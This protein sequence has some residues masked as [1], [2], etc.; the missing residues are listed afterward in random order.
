MRELSETIRAAQR[1]I[2]LV[3]GAR[4]VNDFTWFEE[5]GLWGGCF[6]LVVDVV[7]NPFISRQTRWYA[8]LSDMYPLGELAVVPAKDGGITATFPHQLNNSEGRAELPW[9]TGKLCLDEDVVALGRLHR[10]RQPQSAIARFRWHVERAVEWIRLAAAGTLIGSSDYF[11]LPDYPRKLDDLVVY[12]ENALS[13]SA[14]AASSADAGLAFYVVVK[15]SPQVLAVHS[16]STFGGR[17]IW[18]TKWG[19]RFVAAKLVDQSPR[20]TAWI[21]VSN[22]LKLDPW[23]APLTWADLFRALDAQGLSR[24]RLLRR[25]IRILR[26]VDEPLRHL[27]VG[28]PVPKLTSANPEQMCW[29]A[30]RVDGLAPADKDVPGFRPTEAS[31]WLRDRT[32]AMAPHRELRWA[33]TENWS[34]ENLLGRGSL[35][36]QACRKSFLVIGAGAL[37]SVVAEMLVRGG[38]R[39]ISIVDSDR[40]AAGNLC[41][42]TLTVDEV[43]APK[44][45]AIASRLR[46]C[47]AHVRVREHNGSFASYFEGH[48]FKLKHDVIVDCTAENDVLRLLAAHP[49]VKDV[50]F[51]SASVGHHARHL[52]LFAFYGKAFPWQQFSVEMAPWSE[53]EFN[54]AAGMD[55]ARDGLGC[56][57]PLFPAAAHDIWQMASIAVRQIGVFAEQPPAT[58][59]LVVYR[60]HDDGSTSR[61]A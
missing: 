35:P 19:D 37:G 49:Q 36:D 22:V 57:H 34:H 60:R 53:K 41:R 31:R 3:R 27:L 17:V 32:I 2:D 24:Q 5:A 52:F 47:S 50:C 14:W 16:F 45:T 30:L 12:A 25:V 42:H 20:F 6:E 33:R 56:W 23:Q 44:A 4:W 54:E 38:I 58:P 59:S 18:R 48:E 46:A 9:R 26:R 15:N 8:L 29:V 28:F 55:Y 40:L 11:E 39:D 21:R 51:V 61:E 7:E 43:E 13:F 1:A 10:Q